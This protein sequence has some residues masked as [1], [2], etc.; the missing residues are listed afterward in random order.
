TICGFAS[1]A[2][3]IDLKCPG[4]Q[5][6]VREQR[7]RRKVVSSCYEPDCLSLYSTTF[8]LSNDNSCFITMVEKLD[9]STVGKALPKPYAQCGRPRND[10]HQGRPHF[11]A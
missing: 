4:H 7:R 11:R 5:R 8:L 2:G 3:A 6:S 1:T 9:Y 10:F